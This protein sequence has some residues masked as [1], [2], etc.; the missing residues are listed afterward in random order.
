MIF[1]IRFFPRNDSK[2]CAAIGAAALAAT[3]AL[4]AMG[5]AIAQSTMQGVPNAMQGFSQNRDQPIQI[6]AASLEMRDKKKEATFAGN[7]KVIQG[8]TT[9]TSKTLVVF[10]ES[11]GDKP[12]T[13][14]PAAK[15]AKAAPM[16]SATPGPGGSSSIK[17]LEARGNVVVTQKDQVVTGDTAVFDTK[18]NLITMLG[19][20]GQV[21]LTQCKNVLQGDRLV[22]DMTTGVSRVE[23]DSGKVR[24]LF[25]QNSK[26][27]TQAGPGS[28]PALQ[29]PGAT[30]PK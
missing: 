2:R 16:Q 14:Q 10:Y 3:V 1:M 8:D 24:G 7:V 21:V 19:G 6:E 23:S 9:M 4:M 5:A 27:G 26:C 18:T 30:K 11:G 13:P 22:V 28:G 29:L 12:A 15:G 25:D 17:R 20:T